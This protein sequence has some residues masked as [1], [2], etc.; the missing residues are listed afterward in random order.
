VDIV[1]AVTVADIRS[2]AHLFDNAVSELALANFASQPNHR[3]LLARHDS[4]T[5]GFV[6]IV[7]LT[8]PD[9]G[10]E[11][12]LY[13]LAVNEGFQG[14]GIGRALIEAAT[15]LARTDGAHGVFTLAEIDNDAALA[16][17]R[18]AGGE[19]PQ[20]VVLFNWAS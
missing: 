15:C 14:R 12:F 3:M 18:S 8:H 10:V 1:Q 5:I 13:E 11:W 16:T 17:Y 20:P 7:E 9:K 2:A 6:S 19:G 4:Q